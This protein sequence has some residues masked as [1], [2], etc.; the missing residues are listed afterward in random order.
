MAQPAL[1]LHGALE[2]ALGALEAPSPGTLDADT[3]LRLQTCASLGGALA[4][5]RSVKHSDADCA[6]VVLRTYLYLLDRLA[7]GAAAVT[8][9]R[10][11]WEH[12]EES[13]YRAFLCWVQRRCRD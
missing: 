4:R 11:Y 7:H 5:L 13:P 6:R 9:A 12:I 10:A 1:P 8:E 2:A 3:L